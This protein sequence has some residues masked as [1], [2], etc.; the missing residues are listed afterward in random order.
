MGMEG[1]GNTP[2]KESLTF[3]INNAKEAIARYEQRIQDA[4]N[5]PVSNIFTEDQKRNVITD[6][7]IALEN[8]KADLA[9]SE[10]KLAE[11]ES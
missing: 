2:T 11:L 8:S 5:T 9:E 3:S 6:H 10:R 4:E 7:Q 1:P